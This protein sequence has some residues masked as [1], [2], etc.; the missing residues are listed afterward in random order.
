MISSRLVQSASHKGIG[1]SPASIMPISIFRNEG[2]QNFP[3]L[4]AAT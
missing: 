1:I 3:E 2:H 4:L